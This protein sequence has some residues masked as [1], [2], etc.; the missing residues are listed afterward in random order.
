[1]H[2]M[3]QLRSPAITKLITHGSA[4]FKVNPPEERNAIAEFAVIS[5][6][7][8]GLSPGFT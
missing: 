1:V 7:R 6:I 4:N 8:T 3:L 2:Q 5:S